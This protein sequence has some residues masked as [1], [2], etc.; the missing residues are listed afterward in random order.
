[1][2]A[3]NLEHRKK[4][5][6]SK[7]GKEKSFYNYTM[8]RQRSKKLS[9]SRKTKHG[10]AT[11]LQRSEDEQESEN[12]RLGM[13]EKDSDEDELDRLVLGDGAGFMAK[14][15]QE[16][17]LDAN[18]DDK[19]EEGASDEDGEG[20]EGLEGVDDADVKDPPSP[21]PAETNFPPAILPRCRPV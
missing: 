10:D 2:P 18:E 9:E 6:C 1:M 14:L 8:P 5:A 4:V 13:L 3:E 15:G 12:E 17:N 20:R 16:M 7:L 19:R 21:L 11:E